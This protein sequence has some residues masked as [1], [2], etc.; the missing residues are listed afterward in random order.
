MNNN[1]ADYYFNFMMN[2]IFSIKVLVDS[3]PRLDLD[4][5]AKK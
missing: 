1:F 2:L 5:L 3:I 4:N